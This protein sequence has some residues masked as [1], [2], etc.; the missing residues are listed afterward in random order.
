MKTREQLRAERANAFVAGVKPEQIE[1][2]TS[3]L[4]ALPASVVQNGLGAA[5][6]YLR[7]RPGAGRQTLY[8][9]LSAWVSDVIFAEPKTDLLQLVVS[10]P[11]SRLMRAHEETLAFATWLRRFLDAREPRTRKS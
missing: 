11:A 1:E 3:E 7:G 10:N 4:R 6:A 2:Y 9:H 8:D 5:L